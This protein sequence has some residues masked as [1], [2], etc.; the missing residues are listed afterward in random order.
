MIAVK[1]SIPPRKTERPAR[2]PKRMTIAIG[3]LCQG[4]VVVAADMQ[5]TRPDGSTYDASKIQ[6]ATTSNCALA[7]AYT[8]V[9]M[10]AAES[11]VRDLISDVKMASPQSLFGLE[12]VIKNRIGEW[13][14]IYTIQ[15]D[16]PDVGLI[17]GARVNGEIGLYVCEPPGTVVQKTFENSNGYAAEG[18]GT[19]I[20]DPLF[21]TLF[22]SLVSPRVCLGQMSYLMYRA[23]KDCHGACGGGTD[24]V[25]ITKEHS[26]PL[27]IER[28]LLKQAEFRGRFLDET[29][30]KVASA[31][32]SRRK[33]DDI[34]GFAGIFDIYQNQLANLFRARTGEVI[35]D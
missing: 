24:A 25:L 9:N 35:R 16:R 32:L 33:L 15:D 5:M 14:K 3:M 2:K 29:L 7:I 1:P 31:V 23:K 34:S 21:R 20:T 6:T 28:P 10:N 18:A 17:I 12:E 27:W 22:G 8:C 4:G 19:I 30:A 11:L 26:E 13:S